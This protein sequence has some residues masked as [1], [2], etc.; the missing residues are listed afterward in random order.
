MLFIVGSVCAVAFG[1]SHSSLSE[2]IT[3]EFKALGL[4]TITSHWLLF[5]LFCLPY[6]FSNSL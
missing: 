4:L 2:A 3:V 5:I 6:L 1:A